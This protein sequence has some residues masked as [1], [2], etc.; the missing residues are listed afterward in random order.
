MRT[1]GV[2]WTGGENPLPK[3]RADLRVLTS[4][5][6]AGVQVEVWAAAGGQHVGL[7]SYLHFRRITRCFWCWGAGGRDVV[8]TGDSQGVR[9]EGVVAVVG[10]DA[11]K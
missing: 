8:L 1:P 2:V 6:F 4:H 5:S 11:D 7:W 9:S 10:E 3:G